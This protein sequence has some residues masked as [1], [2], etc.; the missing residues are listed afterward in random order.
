M[1]WKDCK[2]CFKFAIG[3]GS[4]LLL[5]M[6]LGGWALFGIN[7][8]VRNAKEVI[9]GNKLRGNFT[10]KVVDHLKWSEKV[11][12]LLTNTNVNELH[13]QTDP[14]KCAFGKW[15]YSDARLEAEKLVPGLKPLMAEIENYHN[16][17]HESAVEIAKK[18]APAD[19]ELGSFLRDKKLDHLRWMGTVKDA[20]INPASTSTGV[21]TD[22]H[23]CAFGKWLYSEDTTKRMKDDPEFGALVQK[24]FEPHRSLH[25]SAAEI[26]TELASG[27][28][29][30]AQEWYRDITAPL[31]EE[32]LTAID[33]VLGLNDA[34]IKG[35]DEA[36]AIYAGV[37]VPALNKVQELL[38]K[39][40][41]LISANIM[42]D[43]E[44]LQKAASTR[45]GVMVFGIVSVFL[46]VF[47]AWIIARGI[48]GPLRKG[49]EFAHIV[50]TGD[51]TATVDLHQNDEV[52]QL[53]AALTGMADRLN[54][55]VA[56]VNAATDSVSA[57]SEELSASAQSL[58]QSVVEQSASIEQISASM[59]EM[60][61]GVRTN[62][63]SAQETE[64]IASKAASGARESGQAVEEA[65]GALKSI[66]E[67][68]TIIQE[69]ARQT[70]LLALN[71]AIEA[72]RAG[73]HGKGFAVVAA[74]VRK[75]AERSGKAAEEIGDLSAASMGVA[76]KAGRMLDELV[77][78]IGRTAELIQ[79]IA[80]S[81][82]EQEKGV[83]E[84]GA[85]IT[86]LDDVVQGNASASEEMAS[87]SEEL[88]AQA[89]ALAE[90]M[91]FFKVASGGRATVVA[92]RSNAKSLPAAPT[93][94]GRGAG[95]KGAGL[96]LDMGDDQDF[97]KF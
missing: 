24:I 71:A 83:N 76:D 50:S 72:A 49:M 12:E 13:V 25:E 52:G 63:R 42:T 82:L 40:M 4:I 21:Q 48:V 51:L 8:I 81:S 11:N 96:A 90:A 70:N 92:R 16:T 20:L 60:S 32:T 65:M 14:H 66:A 54:K 91:T 97:E 53:A 38:N 79:E 77:P 89:Q 85:A 55:V 5:L 26:D 17:L 58:S 28:R 68:I 15:F 1:G 74:E 80:S 45:M 33:G 62:A 61:A 44:M 69:I 23:K 30:K 87:T 73:E 56:D 41:E 7:G 86:Q 29:A 9:T 59:E 39:S 18:Y 35:Y 2:L 67:R 34:R 47:L 36:K 88:S 3:F 22:P 75:L 57:G 27:N 43:E 31:G 37:T 10:Q 84:I 78:Q 94:A 93:K 95:S 6:V 46:G 19:V 64:A